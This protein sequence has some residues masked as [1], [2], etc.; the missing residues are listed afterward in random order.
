L[1]LREVWEHRDLFYFLVWRDI[2]V[3]YKQTLLGASWAV[4]NPLIMM[5]VFSFLFRYLVRVP[6]GDIPYPLF[7]YSALVPWAYFVTALTQS[8]NSVVWN[9]SLI[10]NVYFPRLIL[11]MAALV[12]GLIDLGIALV[13]LFGLMLVYG[14]T[15][16]VAVLTLPLFGLLAVATALGV[17]LW[18]SA[19]HVPYRDVGFVVV[20]FLTQLWLFL[21]PVGYPSSLLP[22]PWRTL[23]GLNPMAGVVEGFRWA[24]LGRGHAPGRLLWVSVAVVIGLLVGGAFYFRRREDFFSDIV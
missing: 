20:P 18:M 17:G 9:R 6:T 13:I 24:L 16:G 2:K 15:P 5:V 14:L 23:S 4:L 22:E 21:T 8:T 3:R 1:N 19:L 10:K 11:P 7:A 12:P